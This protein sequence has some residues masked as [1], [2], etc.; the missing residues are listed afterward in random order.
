MYRPG[1][2]IKYHHHENGEWRVVDAEVS[3]VAA[4]GE[5]IGLRYKLNTNSSI[6]YLKEHAVL[7]VDELKR[8]FI[9]HRLAELLRS[10]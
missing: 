4:T 7:E 10:Q 3:W 5:R 1:D 9:D 2:R 6:T 8:D